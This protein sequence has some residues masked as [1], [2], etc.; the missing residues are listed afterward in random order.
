MPKEE[1][2]FGQGCRRRLRRL[3]NTGAFLPRRQLAGPAGD[4][5]KI[6][7]VN[8]ERFAV[9]VVLRFLRVEWHGRQG[10]F[11]NISG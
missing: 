11:T 2:P 4:F 9:H 8:E 6:S 1:T 5:E 10:V 3:N 7:Y